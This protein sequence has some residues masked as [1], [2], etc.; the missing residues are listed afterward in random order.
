MSRIEYDIN[1][2]GMIE[3]QILARF[4]SV[5][6]DT[7]N[8]LSIY[9]PVLTG[10]AKANWRTLLNEDSDSPLN[11]FSS[12]SYG[13]QDA[14][15][16]QAETIRV[17]SALTLKDTVFIVNNVPYIERIE[18]GWPGN[19]PHPGYA[20]VAHTMADIQAKYGD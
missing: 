12:Q 9:T 15:E 8:R 7:W 2:T 3:E 6:F 13:S 4:K 1:I 10:K 11:R 14:G 18:R 16:S 19:P 17:L 5:V 20:T